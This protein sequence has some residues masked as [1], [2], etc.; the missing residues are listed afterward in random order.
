MPPSGTWPYGE[1]A[2]FYAGDR[3]DRWAEVIQE[4]REAGCAVQVIGPENFSL[5]A[6][7]SREQAQGWV[8]DV[9]RKAA[10]E[11]LQAWKRRKERTASYDS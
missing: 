9:M 5:F 10:E 11:Y 3:W 7:G 1:W 8:E 6:E 4:M 2:S